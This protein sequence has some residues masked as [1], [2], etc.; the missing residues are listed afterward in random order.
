[1]GKLLDL[2]DQFHIV[3]KINKIPKLLIVEIIA[4]IFIINT[5]FALLYCKIYQYDPTSFKDIHNPESKTH[6]PFY[7]FLYFSNTTFYSL[8]YDLVPQSKL[9]KALC[10]IQLKFGFI[11]MAIYIARILK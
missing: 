2:F 4:I 7:D 6:V 8:G 1:M 9:A 10:V 5:V 3:D 11:I